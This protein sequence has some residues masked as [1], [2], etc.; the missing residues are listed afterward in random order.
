[1][2]AF[3]IVNLL[4]ACLEL[5]VPSYAL[6]LVRRFGA[7]QVGS[8]IVIAFLSLALLHVVN[9]IKVGPS[10]G[11]TLSLV[12]M[13]ASVLLLIGMGHTET[14]CQQRQ[15]AQVDEESLRTRLDSEAKE[16]SEN[17][18]VIKQQMA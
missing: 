2:T 3:G 5:C 17:L 9:P 7:G 12:Y 14:L 8:F 11:L 15:K 10:S 1:M 16:R 4:A 6:R 18:L 13:G